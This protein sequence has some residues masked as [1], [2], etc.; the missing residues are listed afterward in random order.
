MIMNSTTLATMLAKNTPRMTGRCA[1][2][3]V[4]GAVIAVLDAVEG[5]FAPAIEDIV[6]LVVFV[7]QQ[8][9]AQHRRQRHRDD[10]GE[11]DRH[12]DGDGEFVQQPADDAA[13]EDDGNEHR[14]QRRSWTGW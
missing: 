12:D 10:A 11:H 1:M 6:L 2:A 8:A 3:P 14:R 7:L 13:H 5:V 9:G 4:Q